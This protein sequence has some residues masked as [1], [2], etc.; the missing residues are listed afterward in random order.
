MF[1]SAPSS[2]SGNFLVY[3]QDIYN[4]VNMYEEDSVYLNDNSGN[5]T[6]SKGLWLP[7]Y[8]Q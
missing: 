6:A 5:L 7:K 3:N 8:C 1:N 4:L 2:T